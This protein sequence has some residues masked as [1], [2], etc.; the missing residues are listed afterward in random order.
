MA[1]LENVSIKTK[2]YLIFA[3]VTR[4][5]IVIFDSL[6]DIDVLETQKLYLDAL[7]C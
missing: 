5:R 2:I 6:S 1:T 7:I 4:A 3:R